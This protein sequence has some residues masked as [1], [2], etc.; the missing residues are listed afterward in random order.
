MS[1]SYRHSCAQFSPR[2]P[3]NGLLASAPIVPV[4]P[5]IDVDQPRCRTQTCLTPSCWQRPLPEF[6]YHCLSSWLLSQGL[7]TQRVLPFL[8]QL[9][10]PLVRL[11]T[12]MPRRISATA[13]NKR[14][15]HNHDDNHTDNGNDDQYEDHRNR[16]QQQQ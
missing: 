13:K 4:M 7:V 1:G 2:V 15:R 6:R 14:Q 9:N 16:H 10:R 5:T 8:L 3:M 11:R 12:I